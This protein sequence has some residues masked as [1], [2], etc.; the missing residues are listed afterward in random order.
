MQTN[1]TRNVCRLIIW[2]FV[3][4]NKPKRRTFTRVSLFAKRPLYAILKK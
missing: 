1:Y 4:A 2:Q 3:K